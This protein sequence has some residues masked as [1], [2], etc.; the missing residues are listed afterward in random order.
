MSPF[1]ININLRCIKIKCLKTSL[2]KHSDIDILGRFTFFI[3]KV[4]N[5]YWKYSFKKMSKLI[6]YEPVILL[7]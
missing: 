1:V 6:K 2:D 7:G 5:G 3:I 4:C